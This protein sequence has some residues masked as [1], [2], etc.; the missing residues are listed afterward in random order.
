MTSRPE[1]LREEILPPEVTRMLGLLTAARKSSTV[2]GIRAASSRARAAESI[3]RWSSSRSRARSR[4]YAARSSAKSRSSWRISVLENRPRGS[5]SRKSSR[6]KEYS[7]KGITLKRIEL[8]SE[9][10]QRKCQQKQQHGN[11]TLCPSRTLH[12]CCCYL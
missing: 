6:S 4:S 11:R 12:W 7:T 10:V 2:I 5:L 3:R 9:Q 1:G 8:R